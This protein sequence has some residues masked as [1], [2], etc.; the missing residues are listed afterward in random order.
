MATVQIP[1][2]LTVPDSS[3]NAY[4]AL[5]STANIRE[6]FLAYVKDVDGDWWGI[7]RVPQDYNAGGTVILRV[8]ANSTGGLVTSFIVSTKVLDTGATWDAALTAETVIDTTLS[9]T[10]YRPSDVTFTLTTTPVAGKDLLVKIQHNGTRGADTLNVDT[11]MFQAI[12]QY[13][14]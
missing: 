3:G 13:T 6:L 11:L 2:Q 8:A 7:V 4:A 10:A 9:T 12:F 5:V 14:T 1:I